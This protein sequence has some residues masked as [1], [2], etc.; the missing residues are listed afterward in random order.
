MRHRF[1]V[2]EYEQMA[3]AGVVASDVR[4]ELLDGEV[5]EMSPI[6]SLH[7]AC[8]KRLHLLLTE[9]IGR[10][11]V[12]G[13]QDPTVVGSHS[14]AQ[15]D[16]SVLRW[17]D[18]FYAAAHPRSDDVL[19]LVEVADTS[20]ASDRRAKVPIYAV[21]GIAECWL[22]DLNAEVVEVY[23][24]PVGGIYKERRDAARGETVCP[25]AFPDVTLAVDDILGEASRRITLR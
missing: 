22:V 4:L 5:V 16:I 17:K 20:V 21:G 25:T 7:A 24:R 2:E 18:D 9:A 6:G 3:E 10:R 8:V 15:P 1:T 13:V 14:E 19:L 23:R 11:A 12:I